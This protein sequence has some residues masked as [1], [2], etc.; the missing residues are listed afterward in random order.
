M[1]I[2][3]TFIF[4]VPAAWFIILFSRMFVIYKNKC[5]FENT[6]IVFYENKLIEMFCS[7]WELAVF[8]CLESCVCG[9]WIIG[10]SPQVQLHFIW[11]MTETMTKKVPGIIH[12]P[13]ISQWNSITQHKCFLLPDMLA[14]RPSR[15]TLDAHYA[16][17][18]TR[19]QQAKMFFSCK[20]VH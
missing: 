16:Q 19:L 2:W 18:Y 9:R 1:F 4:F 3:K 20:V 12:I 8:N 11:F 10:Q 14:T 15:M 13:A 7:D 5:H 6:R 17:I